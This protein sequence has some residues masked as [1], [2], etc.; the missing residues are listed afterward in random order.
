M[1]WDLPSGLFQSLGCDL[2]T[3][4][5]LGDWMIPVVEGHYLET[6]ALGWGVREE[7]LSFQPIGSPGLLV[8]SDYSLMCPLP[9]PSPIKSLCVLLF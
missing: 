7:Y 6:W 2:S 8:S 3:T 9:P 1:S 5:H 4:L